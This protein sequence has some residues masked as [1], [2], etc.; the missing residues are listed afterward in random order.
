MLITV[1]LVLRQQ[2][3]AGSID[4][5]ELDTLVITASNTEF[6]GDLALATGGEFLVQGTGNTTTLDADIISASS[7]TID[8]NLIISGGGVTRTITTTSAG[9]AVVIIGAVNG[10]TAGS[11][12]LS[13]NTAGPDGDIVLGASVGNTSPLNSLIVDADGKTELNGQIRVTDAI[14]LGQASTVQL[15]SDVS[16]TARNGA[17]DGIAIFDGI[18]GA[19][20]LSVS[21]EGDISFGG[22]VGRNEALRTITANSSNG[23]VTIVEGITASNSVILTSGGAAGQDI[24]LGG[25]VISTVTTFNA[26]FDGL[27]RVNATQDNAAGTTL[28]QGDVLIDGTIDDS[29][30]LTSQDDMIF[31]NDLEIKDIGVDGI[32]SVTGNLEFN[33]TITGSD[34]LLLTANNGTVELSAVTMSAPLTIIAK[35]ATLSE[36]IVSG[37]VTTT[38]TGFTTLL[39]DISVDTT[40]TNGDIALGAVTGQNTLT[41]N[42][43]EGDVTLNGGNIAL[44]SIVGAMNVTFDGDFSTSGDA[45]VGND[46]RGNIT[47]ANTGFIRAGGA[48]E[49]STTEADTNIIVNGEGLEAVGD[50]GVNAVNAIIT[51]GLVNS[52]SGAVFFTAEN[53]SI[54]LG[55]NLVGNDVTV[56]TNDI[57]GDNDGDIIIS[58]PLENNKGGYLLNAADNLDINSPI[59]SADSLT[60]TGNNGTIQLSGG[61]LTS[62]NDIIINDQIILDGSDSVITSSSGSTVFNGDVSGSFGLSVS[63]INGTADF[64]ATIGEIEAVSGLAV[65]ASKIE[66]GGN[67]TSDDE[68]ILNGPVNLDTS[69]LIITTDDAVT[70]NGAVAGEQDFAIIVG[71]APVSLRQ[72]DTNSLDINNQGATTLTGS[73]TVD[74]TVLLDG[75]TDVNLTSN[76]VINGDGDTD[77]NLSGGDVSGDFDLRIDGGAGTITLN[78]EIGDT[79]DLNSLTVIGSGQTNIA[80]TIATDESLNFSAANDVDLM[81][82]V[83]LANSD[84]GTVDLS[85]GAVDGTGFQLTINANDTDVILG[86]LGESAT[87]FGIVDVNSTGRTRL[88]GNITTNNADILLDGTKS[89]ELAGDVALSTNTGTGNIDFVDSGGTNTLSGNFD[90][91]LAAGTG[92]IELDNGTELKSLDVLDSTSTTISGTFSVNGPAVINTSSSVDG[93]DALITV[94]GSLRADNVVLNAVGQNNVDVESTSARIILN[95]SVISVGSIDLSTAVADSTNDI[96]TID[97]LAPL[98]ADSGI[99]VVAGDSITTSAL[100]ESTGGSVS[101]VVENGDVTTGANVIG[102]DVALTSANGNIVV[103]DVLDNNLGGLEISALNGFVDV[104]A[105]VNVLEDIDISGL[106]IDNTGGQLTAGGVLEA[107]AINR[108]V[109]GADIT[110]DNDIVLSAATDPIHLGANATAGDNVIIND[111]VILATKSVVTAT[112]GNVNF[113]GDVSGGFGLN[114]NAAS[115]IADFVATIGNAGAVAGL[116]VAAAEIEFAGNVTS[117]DTVVLTGAVNLDTDSVL[118]TTSDDGVTVNG[119][120]TGDQDF[121]VTVGNAPVSLLGV[122]TISLDINNSGTTMLGGDIMGDEAILFD[123]ATDIDLTRDI[124]LRGDGDTDIDLSGGDIAGD[125]DLEVDSGL[126]T[127]TL[128]GIEVNFLK[129][130]STGSTT[131]SGDLTTDE[132]LDLSGATDVEIST[133]VTLTNT[134]SGVIDLNGG[135]VDA[136]GG[137]SIIAND[138]NIRIGVLDINSA[139]SLKISSSGTTELLGNINTDEG[140]VDFSEA[141]TVILAD[142]IQINTTSNED[143]DGSPGSLGADII[144]QDGVVN[145]LNSLS[146]QSGNFNLTL[147]AG[148]EGNISFG[149]VALLSGFTIHDIEDPGA[150]GANN[151]TFNGRLDINGPTTITAG[152]TVTGGPT[153]PIEDDFILSSGR[154]VI[155]SG[156]DI[157]VSG[158]HVIRITATGLGVGDTDGDIIIGAVISADNGEIQLTADDDIVFERDGRVTSGGLVSLIANEDASDDVSGIFELNGE[159][160]REIPDGEAEIVA[161][162]LVMSVHGENG[163]IGE[164][165]NPDGAAAVSSDAHI[166]IDSIASL[167]VDADQGFGSIHIHDLNDLVI[168][169]AQNDTGGVRGGAGN[170][171]LIASENVRIGDIRTSAEV[172]LH[173]GGSINDAQTEDSE[174]DI[175]GGSVTLVSGLGIGNVSTIT[176]NTNSINAQST[177]GNIR[178]LN[179]PNSDAPTTIENLRTVEDGDITFTQEVQANTISGG[180]IATH[181]STSRGN[182]EIINFGSDSANITIGTIDVDGDV[183]MTADN[184]E[185]LDDANDSTT[186]K[187]NLLTLNALAGIGTTDNALDTAANQLDVSVSGI[188]NININE[189][190]GVELLDVDTEDGSISVRSSGNTIITDVESISNGEDNDINL[191]IISG[192]VVI[193]RIDA[194]DFGDVILT[195]GDGSILKKDT[196]SL[197][198]AADLSIDVNGGTIG[199]SPDPIAT[200]VDR[201]L[202]ITTASGDIHLAEGDSVVIESISTPSK[203]S[204]KADAIIGDDN[205][206]DID[207]T[208]STI[209]LETNVNIGQIENPLNLTAESITVE[210]SAT[211]GLINLSNLNNALT[212]MTLS[213]LGRGDDESIKITQIGTGQLAIESA[214]SI[215]GSINITTNESSIVG[216]FVSAGGSENS[217]LLTAMGNGSDITIDE[218]QSETIQ[219]RT[220]GGGDIELSSSTSLQIEIAT[221]EAGGNITLSSSDGE[222]IVNELQAGTAARNDG[223]ITLISGGAGEVKI[224]NIS[225]AGDTITITSEDGI[226]EAIDRD[227]TVDI[228]AARLELTAADGIGVENTIELNVNNITATTTGDSDAD[229]NLSNNG[230]VTLASMT[231]QDG[232]INFVAN[233]PVIVQNVRALDDGQISGIIDDSHTVSITSTNGDISLAPNSVS[234]DFAVNLSTSGSINDGDN[235]STINIVS[236]GNI[237]LDVG[238]GIGVASN[239]LDADADGDVNLNFTGNGSRRPVW[240]ML[241]GRSGGSDIGDNVHF[242]SGSE[243]PG[244]IIWNGNPI[245][246]QNSDLL[247]F[248]RVQSYHSE[249]RP[250]TREQAVFS[251][252]FFRHVMVSMNQLWTFASIEYLNIGGGFVFGLPKSLN[253]PPNMNVLRTQDESYQWY[254]FPFPLSD[255]DSTYF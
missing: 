175:I 34:D 91:D 53:S 99:T 228:T 84:T 215:D 12:S 1:L 149:D 56:N 174:V 254:S 107:T 252:A 128:N 118:I 236:G 8:G 185:I 129:V 188:G 253:L 161:G 181:I 5:D 79:I 101:L 52:T 193:G 110:A 20:D 214:V 247:S 50:I 85:G 233:G 102:N 227:G 82:A 150:I 55:A 223:N 106:N 155:R 172:A 168:T 125:F 209:E 224:G 17:G 244:L 205:I 184:A 78:D 235:S 46:I 194:K 200:E 97:I 76:I 242:Q 255:S 201:F 19:F 210:T 2:L 218:I 77:I 199:T 35:T 88:E 163:F 123:G 65:T 183:V 164:A 234:A 138:S 124:I 238:D 61:S 207:I 216:K 208:A 21:T 33:G 96:A 157:I 187:G 167:T 195:V 24:N 147:D 26:G 14:D 173:V 144:F 49:L 38:E 80:G 127:A 222:L 232:S 243:P 42:A 103:N 176:L 219:A 198:K 43:G 249:I 250:H 229:I 152:G 162:D 119:G 66:L 15:G 94:D 70:V 204:I 16:I 109:V 186:L 156:D 179:S 28:Y 171:H 180:L 160:E 7:V 169:N 69:T 131:V 221:T 23:S 86:P 245:G 13:L 251:P 63:A 116:T 47:I 36:N 145:T 90:L 177:N 241:R 71:T 237:N 230:S 192:D 130:Q 9:D 190:H 212:T 89:V 74:E 197:I 153:S 67:V 126:G 40:S 182:L 140:I 4:G 117:E 62:V 203:V 213:T 226:E 41:I 48:I 158:D 137:L 25:N 108:L 231:T 166:E 136:A 83:I 51:S 44:L 121:S 154:V 93:V 57:D 196:S 45:I 220:T 135:N 104:N 159:N 98:T 202:D 18:D 211:G 142:N 120:V 73:I 27:T 92:D 217:V 30:S 72:V 239:P 111:E 31:N 141:S 178:L 60:L 54:N 29:I 240:A 151:I 206:S 146:S 75:A 11:E 32:T 81:S 248:D 6:N 112:S 191:E 113:N 37:D 100:L 10:T 134:Q 132:G 148:L 105:S 122:D 170:V 133:D 58:S 246:G 39:N 115:G 165:S 95:G 143:N 22:A 114:V 87:T 3:A 139:R 64:V 225:A 189:D 68:V 59:S